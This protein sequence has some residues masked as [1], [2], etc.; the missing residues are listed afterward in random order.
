MATTSICFGLSFAATRLFG[1]IN[2]RRSRANDAGG[3]NAPLRSGALR[4]AW[5]SPAPRRRDRGVDWQR[6]DTWIPCVLAWVVLDCP[7]WEHG[8]GRRGDAGAVPASVS[9]RR[10]G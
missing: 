2:P 6:M 1:N 5:L 10:L 3:R 4:T 7:W 8:Q 9:Q